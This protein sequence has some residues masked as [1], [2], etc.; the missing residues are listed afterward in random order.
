MMVFSSRRPP[1]LQQ[2]HAVAYSCLARAQTY[3][4]LL[5]FGPEYPVGMIRRAAEAQKALQQRGPFP[6]G[7]RRGPLADVVCLLC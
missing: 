1:M 3:R 5:P 6:R 4:R 2:T 7:A